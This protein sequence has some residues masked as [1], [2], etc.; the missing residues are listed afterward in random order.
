MEDYI[1]LLRE[2]EMKKRAIDTTSVSK[3]TIK[4]PVSLSDLSKEITG[5]LLQ[6]RLPITRYGKQVSLA[7]GGK[8][9]LNSDLMR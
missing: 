3:V 1:D 7:P 6:D 2:F 9:R 4:I 8:L 5:M